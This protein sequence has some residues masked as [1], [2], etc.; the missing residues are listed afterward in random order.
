MKRTIV[1]ILALLAAALLFGVLLFAK[2][3][4]RIAREKA[5]DLAVEYRRGIDELQH[6]SFWPRD[7]FVLKPFGKTT[8]IIDFSSGWEPDDPWR[9][10]MNSRGTIEERNMDSMNAV[11]LSEY[12]SSPEEEDRKQLIGDFIKLHSEQ[13][14]QI[15]ANTSD[16]PGYDK[17]PLDTEVADA[18]RTPFSF[19]T[20]T[21]VVYTYQR[22]G[23][24][25]RRYEFTFEDGIAFRRAQCVVIGRDIGEAQH[26]E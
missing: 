16:I 10:F 4:K 26:L 2:R 15:I 8:W 20:L 22:V 3:P 23:G 12:P 9:H 21:T 11:F 24:I 14:A 5:R 18:V 7:P 6:I 1:P 13:N 19:G 25:V 17:A